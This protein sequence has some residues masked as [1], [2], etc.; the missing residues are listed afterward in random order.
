[1]PR[2]VPH[3]HC[4]KEMAD[5]RS[6][7]ADVCAMREDFAMRRSVLEQLTACLRFS[8]GRRFYL[9]AATHERP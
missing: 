8:T 2:R 4:T 1:M 6:P 3:S 5:V 7:I 9:S